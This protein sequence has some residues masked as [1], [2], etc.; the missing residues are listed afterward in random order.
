MEII[1]GLLL[2]FASTLSPLIGAWMLIMILIYGFEVM[3]KQ[4]HRISTKMLM[5][6]VTVLSFLTKFI[7]KTLQSALGSL[8]KKTSASTRSTSSSASKTKPKPDDKP[9]KTPKPHK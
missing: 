7:I 5:M 8:G 4:S 2:I 3:T 6:P 1:S 9:P